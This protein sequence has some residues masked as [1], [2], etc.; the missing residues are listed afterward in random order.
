MEA[1]VVL[2]AVAVNKQ[3][4]DLYSQS[5]QVVVRLQDKQ[6]AT[7]ETK[8]NDVGL[9]EELSFLKN[10]AI[11]TRQDFAQL[12]ATFINEG[13]TA[14]I[15]QQELVIQ[16]ILPELISESKITQE[17]RDLLQENPFKQ[18]N[19]ATGSQEK[20]AKIDET[21]RNNV[22]K[23]V[24]QLA[25]SEKK[26]TLLALL[27]PPKKVVVKKPAPK[28]DLPKDKKYLALTFDDGPNR[29]STL[30]VLETLNKHDVKAT[31]FVLG[32]MAEKNPDI[33]QKIAAAGHEIGNHSYSHRDLATLNNSEMTQEITRTNEIITQAIGKQPLLLRPPYGSFD[34]NVSSTIQAA[35]MCVML[36][37]VD[38]LDWQSK[39]PAQIYPQVTKELHDG[40][41]V[42]MHDIQDATAKVL[43]DLIVNIQQQGF[44]FCLAS[45]LS[46]H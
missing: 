45:E 43:D 2:K 3:A 22:K 1:L 33:L 16:G 11:T 25:E 24:D 38:S 32:S 15:Q 5:E 31:F 37:T 27:T 30:K 10:A 35:G 17:I 40:D 34:N 9:E 13:Q 36:W 14:G 7:L 41:V 28:K 18:N 20:M 8:F 12:N 19:L 42:L 6:Q 21:T 26:A 23:Q 39:D 4:E 44:S 29:T 46:L